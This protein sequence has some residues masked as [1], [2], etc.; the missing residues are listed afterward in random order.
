MSPSI[1]STLASKL[2]V[3]AGDPDAS[4]IHFALDPR[5]APRQGYLLEVTAECARATAPDAAGLLHAAV[6]LVQLARRADDGSFELPGV[7]VHD[8][9]DF[10]RRGLM[11]DISRDRVPTMASLSVLVDLMATLKM[12]ELQ[13]YMEHTFA[14]PSHQEVWA[15]ASPLT[16]DEVRT[17][18][19]WCFARGISLVPQQQTLGHMHRWL[20]HARYRPLAECPDGITHPW[21]PVPEPFTLCPLDPGSLELI[22]GLYGELLPCF[23]SDRVHAGLDEPLEL[24]RGRSREACEARGLG[25]VYLDY[26][27]G[28]HA[29]LASRGRRMQFWADVVEKDAG[30]VAELPSDAIAM[31][32]GYDQDHPFETLLEPF[33]ARGLTTY[34]CPGTSGWSS[35]GGRTDAAC[36]NLLRAASDGAAAGAEGCLVTDWGDH[37]HLQPPA[38]A[39]LPYALAAAVAWRADT[40]LTPDLWPAIDRHA[41][42]EPASGLARAAWDLGN[43]YRV[44]EP[45]TKS[46]SRLFWPLVDPG[47]LTHRRWTS[48]LTLEG[49]EE[50]RAAAESVRA[51]LA[52]QPCA[53][54]AWAADLLVFSCE[55]VRERLLI[56]LD[57][58]VS[59]LPGATRRRL[60]DRFTAL[61]TEHEGLWLATSRRGGRADATARLRRTLDALSGTAAP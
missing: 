43:L 17:L 20:R 18:D 38:V 25:R 6:T 49:T 35:I 55:L 32:W 53:E 14:Y 59:D 8:W 40:P 1:A 50:A 23:S 26:L 11:L 61:I 51:G 33:R 10:E 19:G 22:A 56:G 24:G 60:H 52:V 42:G 28:V 16:P 54:L 31:L 34:V 21:S 57:K 12:N 39:R 30:L 13:L 5:A 48:R 3:L 58:P 2:G 9:P 27:H 36:A 45:L 15:N 29:L 44:P 4:P 46:S 41:F 7:R 47:P 37:G